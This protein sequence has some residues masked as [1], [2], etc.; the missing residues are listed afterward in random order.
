MAHKKIKK[1]I[2]GKRLNRSYGGDAFIFTILVIFG[3]F[4]AYP[5]VYAINNA[6]KPLNEI[7]L[8]PPRLWVRQP[9]LNNF[10]DLFI[11]MSKS[12]VT[13]SRY[14]FNTV[15]ITAVGTAG[16]IIIASMGAF[17][18]SKYR[19]PGAKTFFAIVITTLMFS[20]YVT[21][22]P[23]Y[24]IMTKLGW[25]DTYLSVIV[26]A[27][28]M[29]MGF[30]LIKQFIDTIPDTLLE[31]ATIDGAK[32][33]RIFLVIILPMIKPAWL[34]VMIFSVQ[35]LWNARASNFIYSEQL[36]TLPY[37]LS[38]IISSGIARAGVGAAVTLFVMIVPLVMFIFAQSNVLQ[39][40]ANS[41]IKE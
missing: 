22:I 12:W 1:L 9:T 33:W 29:P 34:T 32:E 40:M 25:V 15:L 6:F 20:G 8:F 27:F 14:I 26:P 21:A 5:L 4:F 11:I 39:T 2:G 7:F 41:G 17:V 37:A 31:A 18:V 10:Q 23:N 35:N 36:K 3:L 19:F 30:F 28:A 16:L 38:Q 13:F 24:L